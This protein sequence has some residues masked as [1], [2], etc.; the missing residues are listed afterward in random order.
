MRIP[1]V[2]YAR[3]HALLTPAVLTA[4]VLVHPCVRPVAQ[5]SIGG[6][7]SD[8]VVVLSS[9]VSV[10]LRATID[11]DAGDVQQVVYTLHA[12]VGTGVTRW[13]GTSG[14]LGPKEVFHFLAD[15]APGRYDSA[16][17][18]STTTRG[19]AVSASTAVIPVGTTPRSG[20]AA[21]T[22]RQ[23]LRIHLAV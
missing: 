4:A 15:T 5:A 8:P 7:A 6:C 23:T 13:L 3:R 9:G 2:L 12:P 18:V 22:D 20:S 21:G 11:D 17:L 10:D 14:P 1:S 16:T 19:V